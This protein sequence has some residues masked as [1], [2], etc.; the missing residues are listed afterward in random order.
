MY[1]IQLQAGTD[2][3]KYKQA[4]I[5]ECNKRGVRYQPQVLIIGD[6]VLEQEGIGRQTYVL[7]DSVTYVVDLW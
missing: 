7:L 5:D 4:R 1:I 3:D 2:I 6:S